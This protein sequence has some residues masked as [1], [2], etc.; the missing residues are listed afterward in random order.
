MMIQLEETLALN[1]DLFSDD[2][3]KRVPW[4]L[5]PLRKTADRQTHKARGPKG[6]PMMANPHYITGHEGE[7]NQIVRSIDGISKE[8]EQARF[9]YLKGALQRTVNLEVESDKAK[10]EGF[11]S[12]L[13]FSNDMTNALNAAENDY[14]STTS[15]FELKSCLGHMRSFLEH[16]HREAAKSVAAATGKT[17]V[18]R[19]GDA[20]VFL[21]QQGYFTQQ[22][23]AFI[24]ALY[25]LISDTS[26]HP[27]GVERQYARLLRN[28]V[29]EYGLMFLTVLTERGVRVG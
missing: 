29:I 9:W 13:G 8:C 12:T 22:H 24:T 19:W 7:A 4:W 11:L 20:T 5:A 2:Q 15:P 28:V 18:D 14:R 21:R 6:G 25:T 27:L 23:E 10:V 3:L 1:W 26:V 16:L 17:V